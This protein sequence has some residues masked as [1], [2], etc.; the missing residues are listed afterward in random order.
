[1]LGAGAWAKCALPQ[2]KIGAR[3][4]IMQDSRLGLLLYGGGLYQSATAVVGHTLFDAAD[5]ELSITLQRFWEFEEICRNHVR[6]QARINNVKI[7]SC[8]HINE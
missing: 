1:M 7:F 2:Q 8:K 4:I 5:E 3:G 6:V